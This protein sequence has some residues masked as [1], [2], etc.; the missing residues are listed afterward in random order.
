MTAPKTLREPDDE[1][2]RCVQA[3][4][5]ADDNLEPYFKGMF[6][7]QKFGVSF[8]ERTWMPPTDVYETEKEMVVRIEIPGIR[9]E[10]IAISVEQKNLIIRGTRSDPAGASRRTFRQMEINFG[11]FERAIPLTRPIDAEETSARY[12]K[13]FLIV[14]I[15]FSRKMRGVTINIPIKFE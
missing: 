9:I 15:P 8:L 5:P 1:T 10:D 3:E 7:S 6:I 4:N 2:I 13:G 14:R 11:K 12:D